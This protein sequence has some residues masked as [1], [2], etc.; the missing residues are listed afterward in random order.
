MFFTVSN[1]K[2]GQKQEAHGSIKDHEWLKKS[3]ASLDAKVNAFDFSASIE[4]K[5]DFIEFE[6]C[7][8]GDVDLACVR[9]LEKFNIPI[10]QKFRVFL[11]SEDGTYAGDGGE[12][13]LQEDEMEFVFFHGDKIDIGEV[14]REQVLLALPDYPLCKTECGGIHN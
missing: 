1:L 14:L 6:G 3:F 13:E 9:C 11:Y 2:Q 7:F 8:K 12:H 5:G 4:K 10:E